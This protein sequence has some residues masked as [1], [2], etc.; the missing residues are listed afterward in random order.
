MNTAQAIHVFE[1][2]NP[3]LYPKELRPENNW[4]F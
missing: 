1:I 4:W 2:N 3:V